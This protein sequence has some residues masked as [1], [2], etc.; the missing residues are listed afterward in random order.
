MRRVI[1]YGTLRKHGIYHHLLRNSEFIKEIVVSGYKMIDLGAYPA[2]AS[3]KTSEILCEQYMVDNET[4]N[5]LDRLEGY[6]NLYDRELT[7]DGW[8]YYMQPYSSVIKNGKEIES[9]DW[10]H[11][12]KTSK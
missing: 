8:I 5:A 12:I 9:G 1:V 3:S 11:H 4:F 2:A 6:P 10:M 7:M